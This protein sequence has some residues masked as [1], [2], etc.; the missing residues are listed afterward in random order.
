MKKGIIL[1]VLL[2]IIFLSIVG[3]TKSNIDDE[4]KDM[5]N[6]YSESG[7]VTENNSI[8]LV[9]DGEIAKVSIYKL[10]NSDVTVLD[11]SGTLNDKEA[12]KTF[13]DILL[14]VTEEEGIVNMVNPEFS[15][16]LT[17]EDGIKQEFNLWVGKAG[18]KISLMK[19]NDTHNLYTIS[20]EASH[21]LTDLMK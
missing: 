8:N 1:L 15:L 18:Q 12:L 4:P 9:L 2:T 6:D 7:E 17:Y 5:E 21:E 19:T 20:E 3:C 11:I 16:E 14:D 10:N 13:K